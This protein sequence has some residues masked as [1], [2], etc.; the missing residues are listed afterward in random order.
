MFEEAFVLV[1]SGTLLLRWLDSIFF[2]SDWCP[3]YWLVANSGTS[4]ETRPVR[5]STSKIQILWQHKFLIVMPLQACGMSHL[6]ESLSF[7]SLSE[8]GQGLMDDKEPLLFAPKLGNWL[9]ASE[10]WGHYCFFDSDN[11]LAV[12]KGDKKL[13]SKVKFSLHWNSKM[14]SETSVTSAV[15]F[16][17][18]LVLLWWLE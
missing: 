2:I 15:D 8:R 9:V 17:L 5:Y 6:R 13:R 14:V 7:L 11:E 18:A 4:L 1:V 10:L 16:I 3:H 12:L